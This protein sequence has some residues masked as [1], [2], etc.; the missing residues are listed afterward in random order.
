LIRIR[1]NHTHYLIPVVPMSS[2]TAMDTKNPITVNA[3]PV[4]SNISDLPPEAASVD[5]PSDDNKDVSLTTKYKLTQFQSSSLC[6]PALMSTKAKEDR[7]SEI[8]EQ[9]QTLEQEIITNTAE[10]K[11]HF[12]M[13]SMY[14]RQY[15]DLRRTMGDMTQ[16]II[17]DLRRTMGD[18]TQ[19]IIPDTDNEV[20]LQQITTLLT[21][22]TERARALSAGTQSLRREIKI[23]Q[24]IKALLLEMG[25]WK[26]TKGTTEYEEALD[27][28]AAKAEGQNETRRIIGSKLVDYACGRGDA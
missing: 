11:H 3:T 9:I 26:G 8:E 6:Q 24:E 13:F 7:C 28:I 12:G 15:L 5:G 2:S 20:Q 18:M 21:L 23:V 19:P 27:D 10:C 14:N 16:P 4:T 22:D 1:V 17:L 25:E